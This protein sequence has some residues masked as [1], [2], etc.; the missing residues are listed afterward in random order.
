MAVAVLGAVL[1]IIN[2]WRGLDQTRIKLI[3]IPKHAI[4]IGSVDPNI[5]FCIE[6]TNL[7]YFA[8]TVSEVG[9][10]YKGTDNRG[11]VTRPYLL[12]GGNWPRR[13]EPRSSVTVYCQ[14]P[15]SREGHAIKFAYAKTECGY[16]KMGMSPALKQIMRE[17]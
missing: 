1:G 11:A 10:F 7:S 9:F 2:T 4:P 5:T 12:D 15:S 13:L 6:V 16:T 17:E 3:V 14:N 8:L